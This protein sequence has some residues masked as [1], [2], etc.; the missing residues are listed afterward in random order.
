M[1]YSNRRNNYYSMAGRAAGMA[2]NYGIKKLGE[3]AARRFNNYMSRGTQT[4]GSR[5]VNR[6]KIVGS[7]T[8][9]KDVTNLYRR[10]RAPRRVR[11]RAR[12]FAGKV[13]YVID[14]GLGMKT[15]VIPNSSQ[16]SWSPTGYADGQN[17]IGITM[18]GYNVNTYA[19]NTDPGNGDIPW[20]F[21]RENGAYPTGSSGTR[22]LRFRSCCIDYSIQNTYDEG[23][24]LD[25][26]FVIARQA[27]GSSSDP[28]V[29]WNNGLAE[30]LAGNMPSAVTT[31]DFYGVTPFDAPGFGRFWTIKSRRRVFIQ[32][33]EIYSFQQRD[34]ANYYL[35]MDDILDLRVKKYI[36]E[37]V[38]F[39]FHNPFV[40]S[41]TTPGTDVPGGGQVQV[42]YVKTYHYS[43]VSVNQDTIGS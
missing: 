11:R 25:I 14:R 35:N 28:A 27:A 6:S 33:S 1:G 39:V 2:A 31:K 41:V 15:C 13:N 9:Q 38:L 18:Y 34:A 4:N 17:S 7:L 22:K 30:Q 10:K 8:E 19:S 29:V 16:V 24:Y 42:S 3:V 36:T 26:Y 5:R 20:I 43:E 40:D 12:R 37:G 23:V 21:A 32:P